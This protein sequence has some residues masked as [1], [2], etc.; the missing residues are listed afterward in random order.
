V[1]HISRS[2]TLPGFVREITDR[3]TRVERQ[4]S[5]VPNGLEEGQLLFVYDIDQLPEDAGVGAKAYIDA[6]DE[7]WALGANGTWAKV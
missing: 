7:T 2:D 3:V 4:G 1:T 6:L 5:E